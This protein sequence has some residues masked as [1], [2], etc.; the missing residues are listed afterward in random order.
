[1]ATQCI[2]ISE[3]KRFS[4]ASPIA[5]FVFFPIFITL[6]AIMDA[7][8]IYFV[9]VIFTYLLTQLFFQYSAR[10]IILSIRFLLRNGILSPSAPDVGYVYDEKTMPA[11]K[12]ILGKY[13]FD[14]DDGEY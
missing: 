13:D 5:S 3:N 12:G 1:M 8:I 10:Y 4:Q 6:T 7:D 11:L 9:S 14:K 2:D